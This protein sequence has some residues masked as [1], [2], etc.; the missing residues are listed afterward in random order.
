MSEFR[1]ATRSLLRWRGRAVVVWL[2]LA[3][4]VGTTTGLYALVRVLLPGM[5]GVPELDRLARVYASSDALGVERSLVALNE[6]DSSLSNAKSFS[7]IGAY[8]DADVMLGTGDNLRPMIAGYASPAFFAAMAVPPVEGRVFTIS[9]LDGDLRPVILSYALW[10]RE[11]PDGR[12]TNATIVVDGVERTVV[13]VMPDEFRYGLVDINADLWL[14]LGHADI[15]LP[16]IVNVYARLRDDADWPAAQAE[17][18]AL[19]PHSAPNTAEWTWRAIPIGADARRRAIGAYAGTLGPALLV[20]LIACVNIAC[21]LMTRGIERE[22]E[23]TV[24]RALGATRLRIVGLLLSENLVL[25]LGS[26]ILGGGFAVAAL[27][28]FTAQ[29]TVVQPSLAARMPG[30]LFLLMMA[31]ATSVLACLIFGTIPVLR[32]STHDVAASLKGIPAAQRIQIAAYGGRDI[33]VFTE[34]AAAVGLVVWAA[35]VY[36][37]FAQIGAVRFAFPADRVVAMRVPAGTAQDVAT[38]V[39]AIPGVTR[40]AISSGMLGGAARLR[41][42]AGARS[43]VVSRVPVGEGFLETLGLTLVRG[44]TFDRGELRGHAAVA[45]LSESAANQ[46]ASDGNAIGMQL[47]ASENR[48]VTVIGICR[49][50]IDYGVLSS[51]DA[52]AP[53]ELY[54]PYEPPTNAPDAVVVARLAND[55]RPALRAIAA[56]ARIPSGV[57]PARP[58]ILSED[59]KPRGGDGGLLVVN[60]LGAFSVVTLLLAASGIY[61]VISQSV[62][63]RTREFGILMAVGATRRNVLGMVLARETKMIALGAAIGLGFT[64]A[65]TRALFAELIRLNAIVPSRWLAALLLSMAVSAIAVALATHRIVRLSPLTCFDGPE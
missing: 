55:P 27:R 13:G 25:A 62:A 22:K 16:A 8:S 9:D 33:I 6:F 63:Q 46:L 12:L 32:L 53:A 47:R 30:D 35:M 24:R 4:A 60:L 14:P 19:S 17:L 43:T 2:A 50:A 40:S 44:R 49:D 38:R 56:A 28:A 64:I 10:R 20:L 37:L 3:I 26:G 15:H 39:A 65:L 51:A 45:V 29:L 61:A 21:M 7:A 52:Y 41:V 42:D 31:L 34:V 18:L 48:S 1:F 36:T 58:V 59:M 57:R 11:V 54:V 23:L 5:P